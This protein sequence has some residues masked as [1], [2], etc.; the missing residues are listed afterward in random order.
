MKQIS[1][2]ILLGLFVLTAHAQNEMEIEKG[3]FEPSWQSLS[4]NYE[5]PQWF[6]DAKLGI[7]A[8]WGLQCV[9]E[10]GDWYAR[11]MYQQDQGR[12]RNHCRRFGHPSEF[13]KEHGDRYLFHTLRFF[14]RKFGR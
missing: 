11:S 7:W 2:L 4:A 9:P 10:D 12:Y 6:A 13:G 1:T 14:I 3:A 8:H 5:A